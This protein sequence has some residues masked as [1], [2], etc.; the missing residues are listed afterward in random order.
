LIHEATLQNCCKDTALQNGH[1][2]PGMN[3]RSTNVILFYIVHRSIE[4]DKKKCIGGVMVSVHASSALDRG[5][6][7]WSD[8]T[9][10]Y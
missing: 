5:V 7:R 3:K 9:K 10:D 4:S 1:S 8:Q 2:T 6:E